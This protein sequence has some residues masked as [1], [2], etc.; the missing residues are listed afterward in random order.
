M[1]VLLVDDQ[2]GLWPENSRTIRRSF[3]ARA[4]HK[5]QTPYLVKNLGFVVIDEFGPSAQVRVRPS[6]VS[7]STFETTMAWLATSA[8]DRVAL[9][10]FDLTWHFEIHRN[11]DLFAHRLLQ[12]INLRQL[13]RPD[14]FVA[15]PASLD[16]LSQHPALQSLIENW[17]TLSSERDDDALTRMI[18][19]LTRGRYVIVRREE[20]TGQLVL[21]ETGGGYRSLGRSWADLAKGTP[22]A[23]QPDPAYGRWISECYENALRETGA[24]VE[25]VDAIVSTPKFGR[26]RLR[27]KRLML[28]RSDV[29]NPWLLCSSVLDE[30]IDL[31]CICA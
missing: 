4:S 8:Y 21:A 19:R 3:A 2:G 23:C 30:T 10:Y 18:R 24:T 5:D 31:R 11:L 14:D 25:D 22:V 9:T 15:R 29:P 13:A 7:Q 6:I 28:A 1:S 17:K 26:Y 20:R 27:Y 12:L 16:S